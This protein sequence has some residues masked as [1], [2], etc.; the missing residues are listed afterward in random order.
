MT[1]RPI[2][3]LVA[4]AGTTPKSLPESIRQVG[5][6]SA[7]FCRSWLAGDMDDAL[8]TSEEAFQLLDHIQN[9]LLRHRDDKSKIGGWASDPFKAALDIQ[10][11][12]LLSPASPADRV[13]FDSC[14][15]GV[16][17]M[18]PSAVPSALTLV[19]ALNKLKHRRRSAVNF[20]AAASGAHVLYIFTNAGS[21]QPDAIASFDVQ[22]FCGA[23]KSAVTAM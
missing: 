4:A 6:L 21:G 9:E 22:D 13:F 5:N 20:T 11:G 16:G 15:H 2:D 14:A 10:V 19:Q 1:N 7:G 18:P 8:A 12:S 17:A 3:F 23:C